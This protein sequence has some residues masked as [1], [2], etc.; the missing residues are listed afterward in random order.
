MWYWEEGWPIPDCTVY[1][2]PNPCHVP[3]CPQG[4]AGGPT[5][6]PGAADEGPGIFVHT[7][8]GN[9][10]TEVPVVQAS[11]AD[12]SGL[13]F[14]LRYDSRSSVTDDMFRSLVRKTVL[15][16]GWTHSYN[17]CAFK[18]T[19]WDYTELMVI[20]SD[21]RRRSYNVISGGTGS[22]K[23]P[24]EFSWITANG[25]KTVYYV[26]YPN[27]T[28]EAY[29]QITGQV[30]EYLN[31]I[32]DGFIDG[33]HSGEAGD[34]YRLTAIVDR[35]GRET[36]LEY[37]STNGLLTEIHGPYPDMTITLEY[38][39]GTE[40]LETIYAPDGT[41]T[42]LSYDAQSRLSG[43][44]DPTG[45]S[46]QYE[47]YSTESHRLTAE[48]LRNGVKYQV[49]YGGS[50]VEIKDTDANGDPDATY[51][52]VY[53]EDGAW[54]HKWYSPDHQTFRALTQ[55]GTVKVRHSPSGPLWTY[56]VDDS[57]RVLSVVPPTDGDDGVARTEV[58]TYD[59]NTEGFS[60]NGH[61]LTGTG[62]MRLRSHK[63]GGFDATC[64][65][66]D[67]ASGKITAIVDAEGNLTTYERHPTWADLVTK[68][69]EPD[70]DEWDYSYN[71]SGD[72]IQEDLTTNGGASPSRTITY[73][74]TY[75]ADGTRLQQ[76]MMTDLR[77]DATA[78]NFNSNGTVDAVVR[79]ASTDGLQV[80]T[81]FT[82]DAMGRV[83][84]RT[85]V[86][87]SVNV[88]TE[89]FYDAAGRLVHTVVNS[90]GLDL[91]THYERDGE[92][93]VT[94]I[95][96]PGGTITRYE[97][98]RRDRLTKQIVDSNGLDLTSEF[99]YNASNQLATIKDP[100]GHDTTITYY[101]FDL[102][103][104]MTDAEGY[105]TKLRWD[106]LG[107]MTRLERERTPG[108]DD[109]QVT[110][111]TF[112]GLS[113][114]T[115]VTV[116][117][118]G[119]ALHTGYQYATAGGGGCGCSGTPGLS[120]V[121]QITDPA[122]KRTYYQYDD[123][124]RLVR[125]IREVGGATGQNGEPDANDV[126]T[127]VAYDDS[128]HTIE[129]TNP[130]NQRV[131]YVVDTAGRL[132][133]RLVNP[134][135]ADLLT[136][137]GYDGNGPVNVIAFPNGRSEW[138]TT[139][140]ASRRIDATDSTGPIA[141][142]T[143]DDGGHVRT[144]TDGE[145]NVTSNGYDRAGRLTSILD[146]N[147]HRETY[148]Y[149]ANGNRTAV[150]D[151]NGRVTR[152]EYDKLDRLTK[153]TEDEQGL[154]R[155][156]RYSYDG[157]G[158][159]LTLTAYT[160][161]N[162][163]GIVETTTYEY[164]DAGRLTKVVYPNNDASSNGIARFTWDP[165]GTVHTRTDQ[166]GIV[167]TYT[168]D[169]LHRLTA[170]TYS[171]GT[172]PS[173]A[174]AYDKAGRLTGATNAD[175]DE[176]FTY[177]DAGRLTQADQDVTFFNHTTY[178]TGI[179]YDVSARTRTLTYPDDTTPL[180]E[181]YDLRDRLERIQ[182]GTRDLVASSVHDSANRLT[183]R[184][185]GNGVVSSYQY[186]PNSW[187]TQVQ[188][189]RGVL[190]LEKLAYGYDPV[191]NVKYRD[192]QTP[193]LEYLSE[194]YQY[195]TLH[196]LTQFDRGVPD[197]DHTDVAPAAPAPYVQRQVWDQN[198]GNLDMLGNWLSTVTR[199]GGT[200]S[201]DTRTANAVNEY[202]T[203][204]IDSGA[205]IPLD[206][207]SNGNLT[208]D[209]TRLYVYDAENRLVQVKQ[210]ESYILQ[211][212]FY[213]ALGRRII[214]W[215]RYGVGLDEL[216]THVYAGG[217]ECLAE[218][219]CTDPQ[220]NVRKRWFVHGAK[221]PDPLV[222]VD[223]TDVG[224]QPAGENEYLFYL[225]DM[226]GSVTALTNTNGE[227][228]ERYV[229]DPY[230]KT[231]V[232]GT[233]GYGRAEFYHDSDMDGDVDDV[234]TNS[235]DAC[236]GS[237]DARCVFIHDRDGDNVVDAEDAG[238]LADCYSGSNSSP[239]SA[240][241]RRASQGY[242]DV[243]G[244]GVVALFDFGGFQECF[245]SNGPADTLCALLYDQDGDTDVDWADYQRFLAALGG[246]GLLT[247]QATA[248]SAFHNPF[249]WTGQR[250][251]AGVGLYHFLY[252]SY[253]PVL[254]RWLQRDPLGYVNGA[255]FYQYVV[256]GPST[257]ND[258]FGLWTPWVHDSVIDIVVAHLKL[259]PEVGT[260]WK[261]AS[262]WADRPGN[263][264]AFQ[265][266]MR[267]PGQS[268]DQAAAAASR[269]TQQTENWVNGSHM[270]GLFSPFLGNIWFSTEL[271]Y[272][273]RILHFLADQFSPA[274]DGWQIWDENATKTDKLKHMSGELGASPDML[275]RITAALESYLRAHFGWLLPR[276]PG[277]QE[278]GESDD[279]GG[280]KSGGHGR[281][282]RGPGGGG[283]SGPG[284]GG[285][286]GPGGGGPGGPGG[287]GPGGP[288]GGGPGGPGGGGPGGPG[289][290]GPGGPGGGGPGGPG[291]GGPGG[292][293]G[294]GPS[295]PGGG[296]PG[297][298]D[299]GDD[300]AGGVEKDLDPCRG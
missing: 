135:G 211:W 1:D 7:P 245:N 23:M 296:E 158:H 10:W 242:F 224:A 90:N 155:I 234:D 172:T 286:G 60:T 255:S 213:D 243:N 190:T 59:D 26:H 214:T 197:E 269:W 173:T 134:G 46:R 114:L 66:Y 4:D 263:T 64:Y 69:T 165:A 34:W 204:Q 100:R 72:L 226:L 157:L 217:P 76:R 174:F 75:Y 248:Q 115:G 210:D 71:G 109:F 55:G 117:P 121:S 8:T 41:A 261:N 265:H 48:T 86:R 162:S 119:Q 272:I 273:G 45:H 264:P 80:T 123:L 54:T 300:S 294:G 33:G 39:T 15:G 74:Y 229:Y 233:N 150:T 152:Y 185:L 43:V 110:E 253:S 238:M 256:S 160:D 130:E 239:T 281:G 196:R 209:G 201:T 140:A 293:G 87:D 42:T 183:E 154:Q 103:K 105:D 19:N 191:G 149:D 99:G 192:V 35:R 203:R 218:Y 82:Y 241:C 148:E 127:G 177:D 21:G 126:A 77:G 144:I 124:D 57:G 120:L 145:N 251:D 28:Y 171:D 67:G 236:F 175:V 146:A 92:G 31:D 199:I 129:V 181:T 83:L 225:K 40:L 132:S 78:W 98:D 37:G 101:N 216:T 131:R 84:S 97:Y 271:F 12:G 207:D 88:E 58:N 16:P 89:Y 246:P 249:L 18:G 279:S 118:S 14:H 47:Y 49:T 235:F 137:W 61:S 208:S 50:S 53:T 44:E 291:G 164:D 205:A 52:Y 168:Y 163:N 187:L 270:A 122:N 108:A 252:R 223:Q 62:T 184:S 73:A 285:P 206:S 254:G 259:S 219:Y 289:G 295:G 93:H 179:Q 188:H 102:A 70:G 2:D 228:V 182:Y 222:M 227:A 194:I 27:G 244:D 257:L 22:A 153:A 288:G 113:R 104:L 147:S 25:G 266:G 79:D 128:G 232:L 20:D 95:T 202:L 143:R 297:G 287:G 112:D 258:A 215:D 176:T 247:P 116:D 85:A 260:I 195:D 262:L 186:D 96:D 230:G 212:Y 299:G 284:G 32:E 91:T 276:N 125:V 189:A 106:A 170:Q 68:K 278:P 17:A 292:P 220:D 221:F 280:G 5:V 290:G 268:V 193:G 139:D 156:T 283:P 107:D 167:T 282:P 159:V 151:R 237:C 3:C 267:D 36:T 138:Y 178:A 250:Y 81:T 133:W 24:G 111:L 231:T 141:T 38:Q 274:H 142:Y 240:Q 56:T 200:D 277:G 198:G 298:P 30:P 13:N 29:T 94:A 169:D 166:K 275:A 65:A 136:W 63:V 51:V 11:T 161:S 180:V 6:G 9:V